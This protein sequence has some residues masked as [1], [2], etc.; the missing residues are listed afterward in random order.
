[1]T[2]FHLTSN[3]LRQLPA[4]LI[5][6]ACMITLL[7]RQPVAEIINLGVAFAGALVERGKLGVP[8]PEALLQARDAVEGVQAVVFEAGD[9]AITVLQGCCE[10]VDALFL[11]AEL[12]FEL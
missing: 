2:R 9:A 1:M 10:L 4:L 6:N 3:N 8:L 12:V 11:F 5:H 7:T